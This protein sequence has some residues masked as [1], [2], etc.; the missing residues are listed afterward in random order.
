MAPV[1]TTL[2]SNFFTAFVPAPALL[3]R[4]KHLAE[5]TIGS[6]WRG[7]KSLFSAKP[8]PAFDGIRP[9]G[10]VAPA[11]AGADLREVAGDELDR[12]QLPNLAA[13]A[14]VGSSETWRDLP[15]LPLSEVGNVQR[16]WDIVGLAAGPISSAHA[17]VQ[18]AF[19]TQVTDQNGQQR[20]LLPPTVLNSSLVNASAGAFKDRF[21]DNLPARGERRDGVM[22]HVWD[23]RTGFSAGIA[24]DPARREMTIGFAGLGA[25]RSAFAQ[26]MRCAMNWLGFVPKNLSQASKLTRLVKAH[27]EALN[28]DLPPDRRS[29]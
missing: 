6:A 11:L 12:A 2:E 8:A 26:A 1:D 3:D 5:G 17:S 14:T 25:S 9:P 15:Q 4:V 16:Y 22:T 21:G 13:G 23:G 29:S 18:D 19:A 28:R 20:D 24:Y 27:V 7:L 10:D